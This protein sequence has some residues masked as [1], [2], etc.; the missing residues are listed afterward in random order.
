MTPRMA[1]SPLLWALACF[2]LL[3]AALQLP[4]FIAVA[5][6]HAIDWTFFR[7]DAL[8][9]AFGLL[10]TLALAIGLS[11]PLRERGDRASPRL[12]ALLALFSLALLGL[13]YAREPFAFLVAWEI[14]GL[15]LWLFLR[16]V[17]WRG[18]VLRRALCIHLP[19]LLLLLAF[20]FG[21]GQAFAPPPGG[22]ATP[23]PILVTVSF[24][25]VALFRAFCWLFLERSSGSQPIS[26]I[27]LLYILISPFLLAKTLVAAP[28]DDLGVWLLALMGTACVLGALLAL[29]LG[30]NRIIGVTAA[31]VAIVV[32]GLGLAPLSPLA[33]TGAVALLLA[34]TLW[35][36]VASP[37]YRAILLM[38]GGLLGVWLLAQGALDGR[39]KLVAAILLPALLFLAYFSRS[40]SDGMSPRGPVRFLP[41]VTACLLVLTAIY[42]QAAVEWVLRPVVGAMAGGVGVPSSLV[43]VWGV[44]LLVSSP[45]EIVRASLPATGI[46][47]AAFLAWAALYWLRGIAR[48]TMEDGRWRMDDGNGVSSRMSDRAE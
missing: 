3:L 28:W 42:P 16:E 19:G 21:P 34:A 5:G 15:T 47:L 44:G 12:L 8:N 7:A 38:L 39:Y 2:N 4:L 45:Q 46:A 40:Q 35:I 32:A 25:L 1:Y 9:V 23:W 20:L 30:A 22:E 48:R 26:L 6:G 17:A 29:F 33:A 37:S 18:D 11:T 10:W 24:G 43:T 36:V 41:I 14:A 13:A 27:N 31:L